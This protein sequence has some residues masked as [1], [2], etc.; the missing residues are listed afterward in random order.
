MYPGLTAGDVEDGLQELAFAAAPDSAVGERRQQGGQNL[1]GAVRHPRPPH[2]RTAGHG[3]QFIDEV[4]LR[5][6]MQLP[7]GGP[8]VQPGRGMVGVRDTGPP[9][10]AVESGQVVAG[11]PPQALP[12]PPDVRISLPPRPR[13]PAEP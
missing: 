4:L 8:L 7:T 9:L 5:G 3:Y 12:E 6:L 1:P 10:K 13:R 2:G 11:G